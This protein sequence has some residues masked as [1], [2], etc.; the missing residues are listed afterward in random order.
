LSDNGGVEEGGANEN[1]DGLQSFAIY[2]HPQPRISH[3]VP[4]LGSAR[5]GDRVTIHGSYFETP[6]GKADSDMSCSQV[7]A[8]LGD[9]ACAETV[10]LS[11][12]V[13]VC[14]T[15][16]G[17]GLNTVKV[18]VSNGANLREGELLN[19][20]I[21]NA[22]FF[23]GISRDG[24]GGY[25]AFGPGRALGI[26][27]VEKP[28]ASAEFFVNMDPIADRGVRA[29][30]NYQGET[31]FAGQF[32]RAHLLSVYHIVSYNGL[33]LKK[34]GGG[35][36]GVIN[37]MVVFG[38]VLVVGGGFTRVFQPL[39]PKNT[40][41]RDEAGILYT[42][43]LSSWD[44]QKWSALGDTRLEGIVS[45]SVVNG[46]R[47][48][49]GGRFNDPERRNN[50]AVFDGTRW[51][52]I[53]GTVNGA[54]GVIGGEVNAMVVDGADLYVGGS[55]MSAGGIE[56]R[57]IARYDG[58]HWYSLGMFNGNVNALSF[59]NGNLYAGGEFKQHDGV[60]I[61]YIARFRSGKWYSLGK[62]V[63]GTVWSLAAMS[64][65]V[66]AGGSFTTVEGQSNIA[67][68]PFLNAARWCLDPVLGVSS[69]EPVDWAIKE[70]GTCYAVIQ[71]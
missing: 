55:F 7:T 37:S 2:I 50:L 12:Q 25:L 19:S 67:A 63:G 66:F 35:A 21:Q 36:D 71:V 38:D 49:I 48:Y 64:N 43:G 29:I 44:G 27:T 56:A 10:T 11:A 40:S 20:Y 16:P 4:R 54:C 51:S 45:S 8:F 65:C 26:G 68:V 41:G 58:Y 60:E 1:V 62:G 6:L 30:T 17:L 23:A 5:G 33:E 32:L 28:S 18:H 52:S 69:W 47:L 9:V 3:V 59:S 42:G 13:L 15:S 70:A 22:V 57:H 24:S 46:S 31:Y 34:L 39:I 53:C 14:I 61:N